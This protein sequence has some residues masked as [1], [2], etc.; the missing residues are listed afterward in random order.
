MPIEKSL[1]AQ[2]LII[3]R[4]QLRLTQKEAARLAGIPRHSWG[5]YEEGRAL[6]SLLN[7]PGI[8]RALQ[9]PDA[10]DLITRDFA[11]NPPEIT[12][13]DPQIDQLKNQIIRQVENLVQIAKK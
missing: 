2:N 1:F 12:P 11:K 7:L 4:L 9:C 5:A 3:R 6:P 8:C 13:M 10:L